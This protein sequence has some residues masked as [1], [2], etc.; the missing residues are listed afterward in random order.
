MQGELKRL[1]IGATRKVILGGQIGTL[2][3]TIA[4]FNFTFF[5]IFPPSPFYLHVSI[6][7]L[8]T[9]FSRLKL[10]PLEKQLFLGPNTLHHS[11]SI[12]LQPLANVASIQAAFNLT[13]LP[14]LPVE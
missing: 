10:V 4:S 2:S 11:L 9:G 3:P 8:N 7:R 13:N 5:S 6:T 12:L 14:P 1:I